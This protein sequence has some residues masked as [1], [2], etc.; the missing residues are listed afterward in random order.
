[1]PRPRRL[2]HLRQLHGTICVPSHAG[3]EL[4][5]GAVPVELAGSIVA[6]VDDELASADD[7]LAGAVVLELD[8]DDSNLFLGLLVWSFSFFFA[9][10][11]FPARKIS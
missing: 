6:A 2:S 10:A 7:E 9:P 5:S 8:F 11:Y 1:M 3:D 4:A